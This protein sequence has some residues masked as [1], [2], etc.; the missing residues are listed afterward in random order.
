M[1]QLD[2]TN[3]R[4]RIRVL[5]TARFASIQLE[6]GAFEGCVVLPVAAPCQEKREGFIAA[7]AQR[8]L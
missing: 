6:T 3:T 4:C 5:S 2:R 1:F 8:R 7:R